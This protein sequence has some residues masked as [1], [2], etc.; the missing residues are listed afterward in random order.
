MLPELDNLDKKSYD[1]FS[2][3]VVRKHYA[4]TIPELSRVPTYVSEYLLSK[5]ADE[6]GIIRDDAL[7]RVGNLIKN[8]KHEKKKKEKIKSDL[9]E[10]GSIDVVDH[11]EVYTDLRK[12]K[13]F[14]D[15]SIIDEKAMVNRDLIKPTKYR[16]LLEGGLW[17]LATFEHIKHGDL[18]S[19][20]MKDF[21]C[22]QTTNVILKRYIRK[23]KNFSTPEWIDFLIR[24]IGLDP[25]GF[26]KKQKLMYLS[27]YIPL[28]Q[29]CTNL[30]ELGPPGTGKSF[31]YEN[32][33][34]YSRMLVGGEI[35]PAKL[36][37]NQNTKRNGIVFKKD[38]ICFDEINK[39]NARIKEIVPKLQQIMASNRV[40][41]GNFEA[42]TDVSIVT[43]GNIDFKLKEDKAEPKEE[44]FLRV[45][46]NYMYDSAFLDRIH[47][48][49]HGW[50]FPRISDSHINKHLGLISNYFGQI[51]HKLR[52]KNVSHLINNKVE[53]Y[54]ID[55]HGNKKG[56]SIR[57]KTA[58]LNT[59]SGLI[60]LIFP[61]KK[62]TDD[63][64]K[65]IVDFGIELRQN[66]IDEI[67]KIDET[68]ERTI[69]YEFIG[70]PKLKKEKKAQKDL[71]E[72]IKKVQKAE[73]EV[74]SKL[75]LENFQLNLRT[76]YVNDNDLIVRV[77][78][79]WIL[80]YLISKKLVKIEK[81]VL[82]VNNLEKLED[83][84]IKKSD[85]P[86][87]EVKTVKS[88]KSLDYSIYEDSLARLKKSLDKFYRLTEDYLQMLQIIYKYKSEASSL[89]HSKKVEK[90]L[91]VIEKTE[92]KIQIDSSRIIKKIQKDIKKV[93]G[94]MQTSGG[95]SADLISKNYIPLLYSPEKINKKIGKI[96]KNWKKEYNKFGALKEP[97]K[98]L[99]PLI[100]KR[101]EQEQKEK[102]LFKGEKFPL[103]AF[104]V[105][106]LMESFQ[107]KFQNVYHSLTNPI[108]KIRE[109]YLQEKPY[110]AY[111]FASKY[112]EKYLSNIPRD[113]YH[114]FYIEKFFKDRRANQYADVD[115]PLG[116]EIG[117]II[118][119]LH[120]QISEFYLGSADKD[121]HTLVEKAQ[122][123][124]IPVS[125]IITDQE[126]ISS[127]LENLVLPSNINILY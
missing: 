97:F 30:L 46:P 106:N 99:K 109:Y 52:W 71:A 23:R 101:R 114:R 27:R 33:S 45:L 125:I 85:S 104:D 83:I 37:Y 10:L 40:E 121:F 34:E 57:D 2:R 78:P 55:S 91:T 35:T 124:E 94:L 3:K 42:M 13:Y 5:H 103:F 28:V 86:P 58:L 41:R 96:H 113:K 75:N 68:L 24:T 82:R 66:M 123:Y 8:K 127:D 77:M 76:V 63:E 87:I 108:Q 18:A 73:K 14:T 69:G 38:V 84:K 61:D 47:I 16:T 32:A 122:K 53:F 19:V 102:Q 117:S 74:T 6:N 20:N 22:Y 15:I 43:Q 60:K 80:K 126:N 17:G 81:N 49:I 118:D 44:E 50:K 120:D 88:G 1:Q 26:T 65:E 67:V 9:V 62:I 100:K 54:K 7:E 107:K 4:S 92:K 72:D 70:K 119:R 48:F 31:V 79:Y 98:D 36:I 12:G 110:L 59:I 11:F 25:S 93:I 111:F 39:N 116:T 51:L 115:V 21:E 90:A 64:W 112:L 56:I 29:S 105:N 89:E 95:L